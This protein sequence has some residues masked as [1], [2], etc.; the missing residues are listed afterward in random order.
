MTAKEI[1]KKLKADG[2]IQLPGKKTGHLYFKHPE[3]PGKVTVPMHLG[4]VKPKTLR[5]I[6]EMSGTKLK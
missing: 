3:R 4:D 1:V 5:N 2:W 6:E